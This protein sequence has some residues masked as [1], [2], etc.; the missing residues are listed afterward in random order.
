[1]L[2]SGNL[3]ANIHS[4]QAENEE[5][6]RKFVEEDCGGVFGTV[7]EAIEQLEIPRVKETRPVPSYRGTLTLGDSEKYDGT[8]TIDVERYP[9]T[10]VAKPPTASSFVHRTDL[11][12]AGPS[13]QS[14]A[15]LPLEEA[16]GE[17]QLAA[18]RSQRIYQ[19]D[20]PN[21]PG[22]KMNVEQDELERGFEYG[23]TAVHISDAESN[24]VKLDTQQ[25]L[26]IIGFVAADKVHKIASAFPPSADGCSLNDTSP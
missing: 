23:R 3:N 7:A 11:A 8:L 18:V 2:S 20:D 24:V 25:C 5:I 9:C 13:T 12:G 4:W 15:T 1:M 22:S 14:S 26:D 16:E 19:V 10:M 21:A 17:G 6:L